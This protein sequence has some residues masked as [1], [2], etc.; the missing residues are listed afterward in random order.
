MNRD[1]SLPIR[2]T[3]DG[4]LSKFQTTLIN[5][6]LYYFHDQTSLESEEILGKIKR[7]DRVIPRDILGRRV[8]RETE[9]RLS[10]G[11]FG[12]ASSD[13]VLVR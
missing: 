6:C 12:N 13:S 3:F 5:S 1:V 10:R 8:R 7:R 9:R 2:H 11:K 4:H